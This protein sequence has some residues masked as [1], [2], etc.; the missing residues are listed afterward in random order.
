MAESSLRPHI[1]LEM[2]A[3][4]TAKARAFP[5]KPLPPTAESL[6]NRQAHGE[7][8]KQSVS[9]WVEQQRF[10]QEADIERKPAAMPILIQGD[11]TLLQRPSLKSCGIE[12]VTELEGGYFLATTHDVELNGL[13]QKIELFVEHEKGGGKIAGLWEILDVTQRL[14]YILSPKLQSIWNQIDNEQVYVVDVGIACDLY[15]ESKHSGGKQTAQVESPHLRN[16]SCSYLNCKQQTNIWY[17]AQSNRQEELKRFIA[18][19]GGIIESDIESRLSNSACLSDS[20][21]C[22]IQICGQGLKD[23]VFN[24]PYLF[25]VIEAEDTTIKNQIDSL[26]DRGANLASVLLTNEVG[27]ISQSSP[28][29][30]AL[31]HEMPQWTSDSFP[32]STLSEVVHNQAER[33]RTKIFL[34]T[35]AGST[36]H[37]NRHMSAWAAAI[38]YLTAQADSLFILGVEGDDAA[39]DWKILNPAQSLQALTVGIVPPDW[40]KPLSSDDS[41]L[42]N[43]LSWGIWDTIKPEIVEYSSS[44]GCTDS[45][46]IPAQI[47]QI[48]AALAAT[49]SNESTLLYRALM[50]HSARWENA[51]NDH[52]HPAQLLR[53]IG[54]GYPDLHRAIGNS[55]NRIT[56]LT[57]GEQHIK[58]KQVH[59]F[60]IQFPKSLQI[61]DHSVE[62]L[63]EVTLS[64]KACPARSRRGRSEYL[65][66]WLDWESN[67]QGESLSQFLQRVLKDTDSAEESTNGQALR[68]IIGTRKRYAVGSGELLKV[69]RSAGTIQKDWTYAKLSELGSSFCVAIIGHQGWDHSPGA[70]AQYALV[71]SLEATNTNFNLYGQFEKL[72]SVPKNPEPEN[73]QR[74]TPTIQI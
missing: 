18:P 34:H 73:L 16:C 54:Y 17:T 57:Q 10:H 63:I 19:Y 35:L 33:K 68:W 27:L 52:R 74:L 30:S 67:K 20:F 70:A 14:E 66:T 31:T 9:K 44:G 40:D 22:R 45:P 59:I 29:V 23:L 58:A 26:L 24:F 43:S 12:V 8:L 48:S 61:A 39:Q 6:S 72:E 2:A 47:V 60:Q 21:S 50:V 3:S 53:Q 32:P 38:D 36:T 69:S 28:T 71:V 62:V 4:G 65:S 11:R 46:A 42:Q 15:N 25:E 55:P 64:Y 51:R 37:R 7:K 5:R 13:Q 49:F 41:H 1:R 56:Y